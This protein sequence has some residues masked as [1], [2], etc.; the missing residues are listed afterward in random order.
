MVRACLIALAMVAGAAADPRD[1]TYDFVLALER[2]DGYSMLDLF[3]ESLSSQLQAT[4]DQFRTVCRD[5]P[6]LGQ[7]ML[8]GMLPMVSVADI[9]EMSLGGFLSLLLLQVDPAGFDEAAIEREQVDMTG[10]T[11][12]VT[13]TWT[14]GEVLD[15]EM[16]W[17]EGCWRITSSSLLGSIFGQV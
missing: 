2:G 15:F 17:E 16:V 12:R 8:S 5:Q 4:Y 10:R 6:E 13:I 7:S 1:T 9:P 14:S 3:S 11:A